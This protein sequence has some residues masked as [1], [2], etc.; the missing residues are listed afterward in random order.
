[1]PW[2][3]L[4]ADEFVDEYDALGETVQDEILKVAKFL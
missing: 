3:V 2:T 4:F 1:M